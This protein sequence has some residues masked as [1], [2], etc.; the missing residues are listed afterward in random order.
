[1]EKRKFPKKMSRGCLDG[2]RHM[3]LGGGGGVLFVAPEDPEGLAPLP[4]LVLRLPVQGLRRV[5]AGEGAG[6]GGG[7]TVT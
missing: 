7:V 4:P 2:W 3:D 1:M 6:R 5:G